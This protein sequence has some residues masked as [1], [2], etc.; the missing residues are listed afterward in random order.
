M[1]PAPIGVTVA[2]EVEMRGLVTLPGTVEART[3]GTVASEVEGVVVEVVARAGDRVKRGDTLI[4]LRRETL[5]IELRG[6]KAELAEAEARLDLA[7]RSRERLNGLFD[8]GVVSRQQLDDAEAENAAWAGRQA[9]AAAA[10][11]RIEDQL[12]RSRVHAPFSGTVTAEHRD[13]G[14]WISVGGAVVDLVDT[15]RLEVIVNVPEQH[16]GGVTRGDTTTVRITSLPDLDTEGKVA[17]VIP[18]A[19]SNARTFPVRVEI[20]N[21]GDRIA[22]GMLAEV[23]LPQGSPET[24]I[25]VPKDAIV[26]QGR[27]RSVFV[28][29]G[30]PGQETATPRPVTTGVGRG[31][32]VAVT[33]V[34]AG[35]RVVT[36][37]NERLFPG[38]PL[39]VETVDY[40]EP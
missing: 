28:V 10:V 20:E 9:S 25:L 34:E 27:G 15:S 26:T 6:A 5:E 1:G 33:G 35:E 30:E 39:Q 21:P 31:L 22:A 16:Y 40:P 24:S 13:V 3:G 2:L 36:R 18:S 38:V 8:S 11:A 12:K 14:E 32:W 29:E 37:G 4:R 23:G 7:R 19:D 17:A